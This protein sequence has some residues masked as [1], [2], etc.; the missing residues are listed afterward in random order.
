VDIDYVVFMVTQFDKS[1]SVFV[2]DTCK[3][4][5]PDRRST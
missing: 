2:A 3:G 5:A 1:C 4:T